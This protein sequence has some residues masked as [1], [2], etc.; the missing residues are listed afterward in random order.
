[1]P[2]VILPAPSARA[3]LPLCFATRSAGRWVGVCVYLSDEYQTVRRY[4]ARAA[5]L[6]D[7]K[8]IA[9]NVA[10]NDAGGAL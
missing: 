2:S 6:A 8:R 9:A 3:L 1:M 5:A 7:A 10:R 4:G